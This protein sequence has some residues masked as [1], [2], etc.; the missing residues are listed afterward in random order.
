MHPGRSVDLV[1]GDRIVTRIAAIRVTEF[2]RIVGTGK[3]DLDWQLRRLIQSFPPAMSTPTGS[4][5]AADL[6]P[7]APSDS[8]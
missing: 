5:F 4:E 8:T 7:P 2:V 3:A 6:A 1:A